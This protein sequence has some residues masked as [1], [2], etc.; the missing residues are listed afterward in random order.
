M[1]VVAD[2]SSM[3]LFRFCD[4]NTSRIH[5]QKKNQ[6]RA[7]GVFSSLRK[8]ARSHDGNFAVHFGKQ[9]GPQGQQGNPRRR[10][11]YACQWVVLVGLAHRARQM[12]KR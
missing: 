3:I 2:I 4:I 11:L 12:E 5:S 9:A 7:G 6:Q 1:A 10:F 8:N